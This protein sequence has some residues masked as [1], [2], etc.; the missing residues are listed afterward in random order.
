VRRPSGPQATHF[1]SAKFEEITE[2]SEI[3]GEPAS[4]GMLVYAVKKTQLAFP[5]MI[6]VGRTA[7]NDLQVPDVRVS[8]FHGWFRVTSDRVELTDA[9][10]RNG[11]F[12]RGRRLAAKAAGVQVRYGDLV[13]FGEL[14]FELLDP[15]AAWDRL[16]APEPPRR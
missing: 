2:N 14:E 9:G 15:G 8:K 7:N 1:I 4:D 6:T 5:S 13:R 11:T 3:G 16:R 12:V 10:S